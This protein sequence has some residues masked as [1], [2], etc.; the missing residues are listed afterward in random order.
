M[1]LNNRRRDKEVKKKKKSCWHWKALKTLRRW[2]SVVF[3]F[4]LG[5][6]LM[7]GEVVGTCF[8]FWGGNPQKKC[9]RTWGDKT[10]QL[11]YSGVPEST[12]KNINR[13]KLRWN[14]ACLKSKLRN[15]A[16]FHVKIARLKRNIMLQAPVLPL[17]A[18]CTSRFPLWWDVCRPCRERECFERFFESSVSLNF[19]KPPNC[20]FYPKKK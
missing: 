1:S 2:R 5:F 8:F 18:S 13:W 15:S 12:N 17:W 3:F 6:F 14:C 9:W 16:A 20:F 19:S 4:L 11:H 10:R 7:V